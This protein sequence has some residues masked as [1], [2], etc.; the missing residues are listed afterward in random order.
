MSKL[1]VHQARKF[2]HPGR[3]TRSDEPSVIQYRAPGS[4]RI[5][6]RVPGLS[7]C[8]QISGG[9]GRVPRLGN[10]VAKMSDPCD[11]ADARVSISTASRPVGPLIRYHNYQRHCLVLYHLQ[12]LLP[13]ITNRNASFPDHHFLHLPRRIGKRQQLGGPPY[14]GDQRRD[15]PRL[16]GFRV[17]GARHLLP[18]GRRGL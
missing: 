17:Q 1:T 12:H 9:V 14:A 6:C 3:W 4:Q 5:S 13:T 18:G 8:P 2:S 15:R 7:R 11:L 16:L 10:A